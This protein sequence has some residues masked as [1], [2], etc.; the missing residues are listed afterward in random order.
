L[1]SDIGFSC[2]LPIAL[3]IQVASLVEPG[4]RVRDFAF[5]CPGTGR[6]S[7]IA[8]GALK[9]VFASGSFVGQQG[10]LTLANAL[11]SFLDGF[12]RGP[13]AFLAG[14]SVVD[15]PHEVFFYRPL[16]DRREG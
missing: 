8:T 2:V 16:P 15:E 12:E 1:S 4:C 7:G 6:G 5:V 3:V 11:H 10:H 9:Q 14:V 13:V